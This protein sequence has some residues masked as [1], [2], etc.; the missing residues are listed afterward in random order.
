MS[1]STAGGS[2]RRSWHDDNV[3]ILAVYV[4][5]LSVGNHLMAFLAA[6]ALIALLAD[7]ESEGSVELAAIRRRGSFSGS[8]GCRYTCTCRSARAV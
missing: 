2:P 4:L 1:R 3:L 7:G 6:P 8:L 5:A